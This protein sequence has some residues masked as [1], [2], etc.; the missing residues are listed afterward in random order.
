MM[1]WGDIAHTQICGRRMRNAK[2][3]EKVLRSCRS[4][5]NRICFL[6]YVLWKVYDFF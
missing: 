4:K 5:K 3:L 1:D 6:I 2:L